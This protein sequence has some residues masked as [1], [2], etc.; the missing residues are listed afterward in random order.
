MIRRQPA[1][2]V[3]C[4][5]CEIFDE[6]E[7]EDCPQQESEYNA[8]APVAVAAADVSHAKHSRHAGQRAAARPYCE[9]CEGTLRM[10]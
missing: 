9:Q 5:I 4:D 10:L 3:Y 2:R 1:P 8:P 7:T 6:H